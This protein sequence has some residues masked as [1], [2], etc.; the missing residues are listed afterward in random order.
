[1]ERRRC[2]P[3]EKF[4]KTVRSGLMKWVK[5]KGKQ[6][7]NCATGAISRNRGS[8]KFVIST[9]VNTP[10]LALNAREELHLDVIGANV[11]HYV[12]HALRHI[13]NTIAV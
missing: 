7:K 11:S 8:A 10:A 2:L 9:A 5:L 13:P 1:M 3:R 6:M 12:K 4:D